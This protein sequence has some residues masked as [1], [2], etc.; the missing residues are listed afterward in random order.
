MSGD[1]QVVQFVHPGFEYR[2]AEHVGD[3]RV[4]SGVMEWKAGR[5][6][7]DRKFM[8][9][10]GSLFDPVS[11]RDHPETS[12]AF[13]GEW[14]GPSVFWK[15]DGRSRPSLPSVIQ[16]PFRPTERP[17]SP[18]QNTDP[19]VFGEAFIYSNC[20]QG[21]YRSLRTLTSGSIVLFGRHSR[22]AGRP[23]FGL[24]TCLVVDRVESLLP[25]PLEASD[26]G[27][28]LLVDAVLAPLHSEGAEDVLTV[29]FGRTR[30]AG[31]TAYS[32]FPARRVAGPIEPFVRPSLEP[33]GALAGVISP[34]N[35][36]GI[37]TTRG[38]TSLERDAIWT[39]VAEQVT[40]QGCHLGYRAEPPPMLD[41]EAARSKAMRSIAPA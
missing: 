28:S 4:R 13:W 18:V 22:T 17:S 3:R 37:K 33:T 36:Q 10:R 30:R 14:E 40:D 31:A 12:L 9:S 19:L 24:D 6:S 15:L 38:L 5:S 23:A 20:L 8:L 7:H 39:A 16:A 34:P 32:F 2:R 41:R 35:M 26:Y 1:L 27:S 25:V 21:A 29:Y 11:D